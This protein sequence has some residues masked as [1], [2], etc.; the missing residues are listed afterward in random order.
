M[1]DN[2]LQDGSS[3]DLR[4]ALVSQGLASVRQKKKTEE[5]QESTGES[6]H[7]KK[8]SRN[9]A[10]QEKDAQYNIYSHNLWCSEILRDFWNYKKKQSKKNSESGEISKLQLENTEKLL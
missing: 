5:F 3:L 10:V 6:Q 7:V 4:D 9:K 2:F 1:G 8:E